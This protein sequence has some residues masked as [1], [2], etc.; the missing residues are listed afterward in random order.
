ML[1]E[2]GL[3]DIAPAGFTQAVEEGQS[4]A[5]A[6]RAALQDILADRRA[7]VLIYNTQTEGS[8]PE[9]IRAAAE[10]AGVS[11]YFTGT[12]HFFH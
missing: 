11:M 12:R 5:A 6:D 3:V 8:V 10:Q 4:P 2:A 1:T 9:Q 7:K